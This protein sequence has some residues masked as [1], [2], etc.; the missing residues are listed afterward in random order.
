[1]RDSTDKFITY[2]NSLKLDFLKRSV[3]FGYDNP[4]IILIDAVLSIKRHY[5]P[6]V[7]SRLKYFRNNYP[8]INSL[9]KLRSLIDEKGIDGFADVWNYNHQKRVEILSD[10]VNFFISYRNI[11]NMEDDLTAMKKWA[12][13]ANLLDKK[14]LPVDGIGFATTQYIRMMLGV[15][16]VKPDVHILRSIY[17][18]TG[19]KMSGN[20]AVLFI[21]EVAKK[22]NL[23]PTTLD[24]AIWKHYSAKTS[25]KYII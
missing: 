13:E 4:V 14:V 2:I 1:M 5:D 18:G 3:G 10:L 24:H 25:Q 16:T 15:S 23:S 20:K 17:D 19:E 11:N 9:S 21:E 12:H 8:N 7:S 6:F 22:M